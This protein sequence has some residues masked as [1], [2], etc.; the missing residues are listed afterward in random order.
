M[1]GREADV[2]NGS[3]CSFPT[4]SPSRGIFSYW[5]RFPSLDDFVD[6]IAL[7]TEP[8]PAIGGHTDPCDCGRQN[9]QQQ[10]P[11]DREQ[12]ELLLR[13]R[14]YELGFVLARS[15][16]I[17]ACFQ[18]FIPHRLHVRY[19]LARMGICLSK[20]IPEPMQRVD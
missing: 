11:D 3:A 9:G 8:L 20:S 4:G 5:G 6:A 18:S 19:V 2:R 12:E 7:G 16:N 1:V 10:Q 17:T 15:R 13:G 14:G